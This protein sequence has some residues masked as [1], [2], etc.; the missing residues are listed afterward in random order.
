MRKNS[1]LCGFGVLVFIA[2]VPTFV[3]KLGHTEVRARTV[4]VCSLVTAPKQFN[5]ILIS[6]SGQY[7]SDGIEREGLFDSSCKDAGIGL[8]IP[9]N[10][11]GKEKLQ[12]A[13]S[14]GAPGTLDKVITGTFVGVFYWNADGHPPR[15]L[16]VQR[17]SSITVHHQ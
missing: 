8:I 11:I 3:T 9:A 6:V 15:S 7:R 10:A 1:T 4:T 17:M 13:L 14:S 5:G 16:I 12:A 2:T